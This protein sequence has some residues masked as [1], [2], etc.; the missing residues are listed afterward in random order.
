MSSFMPSL[1]GPMAIVK[2]GLILNGLGDSYA[3]NFVFENVGTYLT[4]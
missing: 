2:N 1:T 4:A 3:D